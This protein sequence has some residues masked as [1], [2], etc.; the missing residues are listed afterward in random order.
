MRRAYSRVLTSSDTSVGSLMMSPVV[1]SKILDISDVAM[2]P[3]TMERHDSK[4]ALSANIG[5]AD[6]RGG[7]AGCT[8]PWTRVGVDVAG[9][10]DTK[11]GT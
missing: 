3:R 8:G 4:K 2:R 1:L 9:V 7:S 11:V 5:H 6:F 10:K